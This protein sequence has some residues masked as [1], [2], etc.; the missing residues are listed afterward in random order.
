[1]ADMRHESVAVRFL[2][3]MVEHERDNEVELEIG[4][5]DLR[6]AFHKATRLQALTCRQSFPK[7]QI[8]EAGPHRVQRIVLAEKRD[9]L[10]TLILD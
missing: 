4:R 1:M 9:G 2:A 6:P 3:G 10:S 7:Q 5:F 8:L